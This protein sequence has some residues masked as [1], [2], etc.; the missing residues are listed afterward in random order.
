MTEYIGVC[1]AAA[2]GRRVRDGAEVSG[3][4]HRVVSS[5]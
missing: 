1:S 4:T 2:S 5:W 3:A